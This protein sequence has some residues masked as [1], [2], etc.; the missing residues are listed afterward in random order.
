[1]TGSCMIPLPFSNQY[2][3]KAA[4]LERKRESLLYLREIAKDSGAFGD[5]P[6]EDGCE[7]AR[8]TRRAV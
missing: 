6:T 3:K 8:S 1:M 4:M 2:K 7:K 5:V